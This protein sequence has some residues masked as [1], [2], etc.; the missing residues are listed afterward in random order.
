MSLIKGLLRNR[1][2]TESGLSLHA[3]NDF[4]E[5]AVEVIELARQK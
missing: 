5:A 1:Q 4:D 2:I 3:F